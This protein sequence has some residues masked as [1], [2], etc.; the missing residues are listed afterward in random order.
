MKWNK[1]PAKQPPFETDLVGWRFAN[2][3]TNAV[4]KIDFWLPVVLKEVKESPKGKVFIFEN[5]LTK[6]LLEDI[7]HWA[8]PTKPKE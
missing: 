2:T 8:I 4:I 3:G 6:D 1:L 7:T 5:Q